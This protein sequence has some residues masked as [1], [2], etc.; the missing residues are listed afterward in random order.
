MTMIL[1]QLAMIQGFNFWGKINYVETTSMMNIIVLNISQL[2][3][4]FTILRYKLEAIF[5]LNWSLK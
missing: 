2:R 1:F 4:L 3:L 5:F